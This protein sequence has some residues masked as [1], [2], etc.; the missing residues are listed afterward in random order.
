MQ[1]EEITREEWAKF[2]DA[3]SRQH[4]GWLATVEVLGMD[5]GAQE[6][7]NDLPLVGITADLKGTGKDSISIIV[8]ESTDD[9]ITHTITE[10]TSVRLEKADSGADEALEIE[11]KSSAT[12]ILRFRSAMLP[13]VVDGVVPELAERKS[14]GGS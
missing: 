9:H 5:L 10:P 3:F 11:S 6:E 14:S 13:E 8:G 1:T 4:E 2:F 7:A 12:T